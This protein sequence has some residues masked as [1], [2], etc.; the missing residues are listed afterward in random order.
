MNIYIVSYNSVCIHLVLLISYG[1]IYVK[2]KDDLCVCVLTFDLITV[3][4]TMVLL[5]HE[6]RF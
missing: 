1:A 6:Q 3:T 4:C 5:H 2:E